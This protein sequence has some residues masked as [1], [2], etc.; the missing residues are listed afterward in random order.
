MI[1][2]VTRTMIRMVV[3]TIDPPG[4]SRDKHH[5]PKFHA[6]RACANSQRISM[7]SSGA[8]AWLSRGREALAQW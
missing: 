8:H 5:R 4:E 7:A 3:R 1:H 2:A 6:C